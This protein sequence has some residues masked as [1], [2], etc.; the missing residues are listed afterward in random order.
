MRRKTLFLRLTSG[1]HRNVTFKD[2]ADLVEAFGFVQTHGK[3][4]HLIYEHPEVEDILNLQPM[5]GEAKP[6]QIRQFLK[7]VELYNLTM[8]D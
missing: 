3:G 1:H 2:F 4:S 7:I 5:R 8:E 6:Y